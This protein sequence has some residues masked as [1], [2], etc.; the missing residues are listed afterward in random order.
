MRSFSE[1]R[2]MKT[3]QLLYSLP[4][5][6]L[7]I[8]MGKFLAMAAIFAIPCAVFCL[9]PIIL[10]FFA[11]GSIN[12]IMSYGAIL[13]YY[14]LGCAIIAICMF[15][16]SLTESQ[17]ISAI[18]SVAAILLVYFLAQ[19]STYI[20]TDD[21]FSLMVIVILCLAVALIVYSA[22]KNYI[23]AIAVGGVLVA[24]AVIVYFIKPTL[25]VGLAPA[26]IGSICVFTRVE[27][28]GNSVFDIT[29]YIYYLSLIALFV[30]ATVQ[31]FEKRRWN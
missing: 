2:K 24:A 15:I 8:V 26:M 17:V 30:F 1:E 22:T 21:W 27:A 23:A 28:F 20:P 19:F 9:Y 10:T 5:T 13:C 25:Y 12:Y 16:S 31:T 29:A 3:D 14:L 4:I 18:I 7:Q 6:T 11:Q